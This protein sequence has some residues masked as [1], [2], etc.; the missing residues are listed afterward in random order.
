MDEE[1]CTEKQ[2]REIFE[3]KLKDVKTKQDLMDYMDFIEGY[4]HDYGTVVAGM[5]FTMRAAFQ[6]MNRGKCGGITGFQAGFLGWEMIKEFMDVDGPAKLLDYNKMLFP[7]Y[8]DSFRK[9]ITK[10]TWEYIQEEAKK[11]LSDLPTSGRVIKHWQGIVEGKIP[12]GYKIK[13]N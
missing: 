11:K 9:T 3:E 2:A 8:E 5:A 13:E 1:L 6:V 7:Q 10:D 12:F 4:D